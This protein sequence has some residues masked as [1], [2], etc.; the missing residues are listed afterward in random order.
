MTE[1]GKKKTTIENDERQK[2]TRAHTQEKKAHIRQTTLNTIYKI[3][4]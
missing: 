3:H 1:N 4:R 2:K